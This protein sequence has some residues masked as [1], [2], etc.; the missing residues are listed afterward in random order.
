M[1]DDQDGTRFWREEREE[2]VVYKAY[3]KRVTYL[4]QARV[5]DSAD[6]WAGQVQVTLTLSGVH[7]SSVVLS[8]DLRVYVIIMHTYAWHHDI[9]YTFDTWH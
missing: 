7:H 4:S 1:Q 3:L 2:G 6:R 9:P 8:T 5:S